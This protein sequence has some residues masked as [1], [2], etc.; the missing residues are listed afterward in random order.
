M[1]NEKVLLGLSAL[2]APT[3]GPV[4]LVVFVLSVS[5]VSVVSIGVDRSIDRAVGITAQRMMHSL[6]NLFRLVLVA[7]PDAL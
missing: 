6:L 7:T 4:V 1:K 2:R 3:V 5:I